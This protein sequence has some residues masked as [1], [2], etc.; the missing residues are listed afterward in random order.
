MNIQ[1]ET[2]LASPGFSTFPVY[3]STK[4]LQDSFITNTIGV[5]NNVEASLPLTPL[6]HGA[7]LLCIVMISSTPGSTTSRGSGAAT[8]VS[9][10]TKERC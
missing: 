2:N 3:A 1:K 9:R 5:A 10:K 6:L 7:A 8:R 4:A